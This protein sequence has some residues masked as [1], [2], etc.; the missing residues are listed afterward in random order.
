VSAATGLVIR[1]ATP[2]DVPLV[3]SLI[4]AL[5]EY[6]R[7][8]EKVTGTVEMLRAALFGP[9]PSAEA[10]IAESGGH[11]VGFA[12]FHST[13]STWQCQPGIWL[14]D[15]F[16]PVEHRRGGVG[17]ALLRHV[18]QIAVAR[19]CGRLEW[20][21]LDWNTPALDFY[22]RLGAERLPE[23]ELHRLEGESLARVAQ[24]A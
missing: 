13:F 3:H 9:Q 24:G 21:A 23:W 8:P 2:A 12:V 14:E 16:V 1:D 11:A 10:V 19:D 5:A 7:A 4:V 20:N 6:E 18:A 22:Q 15:I 17:G